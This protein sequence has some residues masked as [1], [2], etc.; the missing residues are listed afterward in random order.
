MIG[1]Y[2]RN[3]GRPQKKNQNRSEEYYGFDKW[4]E[5]TQ[6]FLAYERQFPGQF[7]LVRYHDLNMCTETEVAK[8]FE[9]C[10]LSFDKRTI[11]FINESK[12]RHDTDRARCNRCDPAQSQP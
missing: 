4:K 3:G 10:E 8:I 2:K 1:I 9:F 12:G 6:D 5:A 7:K 11:Q